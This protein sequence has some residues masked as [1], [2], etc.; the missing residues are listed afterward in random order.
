MGTAANRKKKRWRRLVIGGIASLAIAGGAIGLWQV[1]GREA[2][3]S[4]SGADAT[5]IDATGIGYRYGTFDA[6]SI[7]G[8]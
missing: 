4:G 1:G 5:S 7:R 2:A 3:V 6:T 8:W